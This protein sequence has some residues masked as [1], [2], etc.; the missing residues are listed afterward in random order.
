MSNPIVINNH[1][2]AADNW[3]HAQ[4]AMARHG[5][6]L[7]SYTVDHDAVSITYGCQ[8]IQQIGNFHID[9]AYP[10]TKKQSLWR[11][12]LNWIK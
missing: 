11:K 2:I 8:T 3:D 10:P 4:A 9:I 7:I 1:I 12:F 6:R 5:I